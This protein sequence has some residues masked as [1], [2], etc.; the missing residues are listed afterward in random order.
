ML[1]GSETWAL[2][3][4]FLSRL[5]RNDRAMIRWTCNTKPGQ[6]TSTQQLLQ[7]HDK[8]TQ[9]QRPP[10]GKQ[11]QMVWARPEKPGLDQQML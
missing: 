4:A 7:M 10:K 11:A 3:E 5:L 6:K 2:T 1:H 9:P 8:P